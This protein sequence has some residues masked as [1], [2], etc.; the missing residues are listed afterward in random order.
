ML[1][2]IGK[3]KSNKYLD[4]VLN[5]DL[6]CTIEKSLQSSSS[7]KNVSII[8]K[9]KFSWIISSLKFSVLASFLYFGGTYLSE[10]RLFKETYIMKFA[11]QQS[12]FYEQLNAEREKSNKKNNHYLQVLKENKTLS[13]QIVNL[14]REIYSKDDEY[15]QSL[16]KRT[17]EQ[18]SIFDSQLKV[19][20]DEN[21]KKYD[22]Y[23][24]V[25][26]EN[27]TLSEQIVNLER[28]IYS[29]DDEY[30]KMLEE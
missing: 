17:A 23:L 15:E 26:K 25:L 2:L 20:R 28:E 9:K 3:M 7:V 16:L 4:D 10:N 13:E 29:K 12:V 27:K 1:I 18:Q 8:R 21:N 11:E 19:E 30:E 14:E 22:G 6:G 24:Q 5:M